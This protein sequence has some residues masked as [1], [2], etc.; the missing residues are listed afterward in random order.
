MNWSH[1]VK[2]F[3]LIKFFAA[4][5]MAAAPWHALASLFHHRCCFS[6]EASTQ[7]LPREASTEKWEEKWLTPPPVAVSATV[8][9]KGKRKG[10]G[11]DLS[12][13]PTTAL[14]WIVR[15]C[16]NLPVSL[17]HKLFRLRQVRLLCPPDMDTQHQTLKRVSTHLNLVPVLLLLYHT[18]YYHNIEE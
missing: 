13:T 14:K 5:L 16:P 18:S 4:P 11:N 3:F 12:S 10:T 15:C 9:V 7:Q 8:E 2:I 1:R 6:P 17:L